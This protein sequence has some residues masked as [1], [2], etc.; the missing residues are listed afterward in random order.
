M[1]ISDYLWASYVVA[2]MLA[3]FLGQVMGIPLAIY[4]FMS[5]F[6]SSWQDETYLTIILLGSIVAWMIKKAQS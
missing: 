1:S 5:Q 3:P 4:V 6:S 2:V